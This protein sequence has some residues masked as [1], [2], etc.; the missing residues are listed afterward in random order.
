[1]DIQVDDVRVDVR[2]RAPHRIE[3]LLSCE[4]LAGMA[5]EV[6]EQCE[7]AGRQVDR[8]VADLGDVT[9]LVEA[10]VPGLERSFGGLA[11]RLPRALILAM[12]SAKANGFG[13]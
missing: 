1:M 5:D 3:D 4:D 6:A 11:G 9:E 7:L 13:R 8:P 10:Q 2:L 12:S